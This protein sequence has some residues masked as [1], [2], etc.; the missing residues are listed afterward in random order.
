M[1]S[2]PGP[3]LH[4]R[5]LARKTAQS[6]WV[7]QLNRRDG[8]TNRISVRSHSCS[9]PSQTAWLDTSPVPPWVPAVGGLSV[10]TSCLSRNHCCGI[11]TT[12]CREANPNWARFS[13]CCLH[14][15]KLIKFLL[16]FSK[17]VLNVSSIPGMLCVIETKLIKMAEASTLMEIPFLVT[18]GDK[19]HINTYN[20][21]TNRL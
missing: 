1:W 15:G 5:D 3:V 11:I 20:V 12:S 2:L 4:A 7:S 17:C 16:S 19:K 10:R 9:A 8:H 18:R 21:W 6:A 14:S 13:G